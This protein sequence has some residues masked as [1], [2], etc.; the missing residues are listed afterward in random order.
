MVIILKIN[1]KKYLTKKLAGFLGVQ[2]TPISLHQPTSILI[3]LWNLLYNCAVFWGVLT[4]DLI[5]TDAMVTGCGSNTKSFFGFLL[6]NSQK[7][8]AYIHL[9]IMGYF[10][11]YGRQLVAAFDAEHFQVIYK[12]KRRAVITFTAV[13][14]LNHLLLGLAVRESARVTL[15]LQLDGWNKFSAF[16]S[17]NSI[18][19][20]STWLYNLLHYTQ[21]ANNQYLICLEKNFL[22]SQ[23]SAGHTLA[24]IQRLSLSNKHINVLLSLPTILYFCTVT[25]ALIIYSSTSIICTLKVQ[26]L[27]FLLVTSAYIL[28]LVRLN[29][30]SKQTLARIFDHIRHRQVEVK[31]KTMTNKSKKKAQVV[32]VKLPKK[33][34]SRQKCLK[35]ISTKRLMTISNRQIKLT[36]CESLYSTYLEIHIFQLI[37]LNCQTLWQAVLFIFLYVILF[38][39][40]VEK[41]KDER[42]ID[43]EL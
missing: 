5:N 13:L 14:F 27:T 17:F 31:S 28:Y 23:S 30:Q 35:N 20:L 22:S 40:T 38:S 1:F 4:L 29:W 42:I 32:Q 26:S 15:W 12:S 6:R 21:H 10:L 3:F 39:Q 7:V 43:V 41:M 2:L 24:K 11:V 37:V 9:L 33:L 8:H 34:L 36:E 25:L 16:I 18:F 19:T